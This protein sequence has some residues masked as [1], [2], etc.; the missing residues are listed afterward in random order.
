MEVGREN[1]GVRFDPLHDGQRLGLLQLVVPVG[2]V[3]VR[4]VT[5]EVAVVGVGPAPHPLMVACKCM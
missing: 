3:L 1:E 5:V 2:E 4:E